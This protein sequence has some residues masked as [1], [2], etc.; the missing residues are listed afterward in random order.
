MAEEDMA[1]FALVLREAER[2]CLQIAKD[3]AAA[4]TDGRSNLLPASAEG[5]RTFGPA[6][7]AAA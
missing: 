3:A 2:V 5:E 4:R 6:I 1:R 7:V